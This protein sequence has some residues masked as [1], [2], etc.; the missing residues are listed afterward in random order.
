MMVRMFDRLKKLVTDATEN[1]KETVANQGPPSLGAVPPVGPSPDGLASV[2]P[3]LASA[4]VGMAIESIDPLGALGPEATG[5]IGSRLRE[6]LRAAGG[7]GLAPGEM[8][9]GQNAA[10]E[11]RMRADGMS[12]EQIAAMNVHLADAAREHR[13][14]SWTLTFANGTRASVQVFTIGDPA[15]EFYRLQSRYRFE[16]TSDGLAQLSDSPLSDYVR[17]VRGAPYESYFIGGTV[18]ARGREHEAVAKS[19]QLKSVKMPETLAA[20]AALALRCVEG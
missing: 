10:R 20:L 11:E 12:E 14:H 4:Y 5:F 15:S 6:R 16:N 19:S 7:D 2:D 13:Q 9:A 1:Y 17:D 3:G 18:V 8:V